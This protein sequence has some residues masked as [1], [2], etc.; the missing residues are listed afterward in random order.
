M[1]EAEGVEPSSASDQNQGDYMLSR[2]FKGDEKASIDKLSLIP[3]PAFL[4]PTAW[5]KHG[6][7]EFAIVAR[8]S[9]P[10]T[11]PDLMSHIN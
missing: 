2:C 6:W 5:R 1:V 9:G 11:L 7:N 10:Q 3:P 8:G 4:I